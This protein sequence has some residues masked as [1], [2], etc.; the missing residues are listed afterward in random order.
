MPS[1]TTQT[2][3]SSSSSQKGIQEIITAYKNEIRT[4]GIGDELYKYHLIQDFQ[5]K[6]NIDTPDFGSLIKSL[7]FGNLMFHIGRTT[8]NHIASERPEELRQSFRYL[9]DENLLVKDRISGFLNQLK[10]IYEG[11]KE[12]EHNLGHDE[13]SV[14]VFLSFRY[15]DKYIL[16]KNSFYKALCVKL[17]IERAAAGS[18]YLHYLELATEIRD[19]YIIND[20]ELIDQ[21][22]K[23][24]DQ[25]CYPDRSKNI[26]TQDVLYTVLEKRSNL[27]FQ[28]L[29]YQRLKEIGNRDLLEIYFSNLNSLFID[30]NLNDDDSKIFC[31]LRK[32]GITINF[33][34][35]QRYIHNI[36]RDGD[37]FQMS[38]IINEADAEKYHPSK[39][40]TKSE[41]SGSI[42]MT[43]LTIYLT[44]E[45]KWEADNESLL[46]DC[47]KALAQEKMYGRDN[48][49]QKIF[50][51]T[52][53]P[54][55]FDLATNIAM[56]KETFDNIFGNIGKGIANDN[57]P[58]NTIVSSPHVSRNIILYG[59]PGT[60]KTYRTIDLSVE[61][62]DGKNNGHKNNK[63]RFDELL[64][65]GQIQ[66]V[67]FHQ[68]YSYEDFVVGLRPIENAG[69]LLF[70]RHEGIFY[71]MSKRAEKNYLDYMSGEST[72]SFED[73][74]Q[75]YFDEVI[76]GKSKDVNMVSGVHFN[77]YDIT[78]TSIKFE[79]TSGDRTHSLSISTLS[80]IYHGRREMIGGLKY[81][82][83]PIV[84]ELKKLSTSKGKVQ[85]R[86]YVL[87][88]D[89]INRANISRVFGELI[90]LIEEDK[91][92]GGE[93]ELKVT[94]PNGE[95]NFSLPPNLFI[96]GTMNTADKSI[97]QI[98][99]AL[100]RRFEF[101]PEYPRPELLAAEP[102]AFLTEVNK[103]I[104]EYKKSKDFLIGHGYFMG[105]SGALME[106]IIEFKIR[107]LLNEYFPGRLD[108]VENILKKAWF[109]DKEDNI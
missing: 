68:N 96:I 107:P 34:Y 90:T 18:K 41:F 49:L 98:D 81:Y 29:L 36:R 89:E 88:I 78:D 64:R 57:L 13:R 101:Q 43:F 52:H 102:S 87:I 11:I 2:S 53:N 75:K 46:K 76:E 84:K 4:N 5:K 37:Q 35:G 45:L 14:S 8:L 105:N 26:L 86:N 92:L 108:I 40:L 54:L 16:Y 19:T 62:I 70:Q 22:E 9:F 103:L 42:P 47:S 17:N 1:E 99:I 83:D 27:K 6:W 44:D 33:S 106:D 56:R 74:F 50:K 65:E 80:D 100:R 95:R 66:F 97:A 59:P 32:D 85:L 61:I 67:T 82:Y 69:S 79:K 28:K 15:P 31:S 58:E 48:S 72:L 77:V 104:Y 21:V 39:D 93:N 10:E 30:N 51:G 71:E 55:V 109:N 12:E 94:L 20:K 73:V 63:K 38:Y 24:K 23:L 25:G 3:L 7:D 60:G 91:R